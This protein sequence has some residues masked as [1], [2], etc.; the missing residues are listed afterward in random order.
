MTLTEKRAQSQRTSQALT[1]TINDAVVDAIQSIKG[2]DIV[3]LDLRKVQDAPAD[4][5]IVCHGDSDTQVRAIA[6]NISKEVK[7]HT[8]QIPH[9]E[10]QRNGTW[11]IVDYFT[12]V[13]HVF[14][15]DTRKF[16]DIEALWGDADAVAYD[17]L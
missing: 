15:K 16:Y 14:Y 13:V 11:V 1:A 9:I 17:N 8:G 4:Y 2:R 10:G 3:K 7:A 12:T 5:F 6:S